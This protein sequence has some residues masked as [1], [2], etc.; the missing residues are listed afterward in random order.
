[1]LWVFT[2]LWIPSKKFKGPLSPE[3]EIPEY[4]DNGFQYYMTTCLLYTLLEVII[5]VENPNYLLIDTISHYRL[6]IP[7]LANPL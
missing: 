5:K 3:G 6:F 2:W 7:T 1:L 4:Q